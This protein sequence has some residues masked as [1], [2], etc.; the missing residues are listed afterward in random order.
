MKATCSKELQCAA[1]M[2]DFLPQLN[3]A[4]ANPQEL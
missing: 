3:I 1:I 2:A 4:P